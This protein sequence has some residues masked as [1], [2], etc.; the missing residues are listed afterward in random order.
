MKLSRY[1]GK[2]LWKKEM[3]APFGEEK[4][5]LIYSG[6]RVKPFG[7]NRTI[8]A[9]TLPSSLVGLMCE[10]PCSF[11]P[12]SFQTLKPLATA[13]VT[14]S[15][16]LDCCRFGKKHTPPPPLP[17]ATTQIVPDCYMGCLF[18]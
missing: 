9:A 6:F 12:S 7:C 14:I 10:V 16:D 18:G 2:I 4:F 13:K 5:N 15:G 3:P 11:L 1:Q 17:G 8:S